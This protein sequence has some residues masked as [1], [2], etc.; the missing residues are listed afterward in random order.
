MD[1]LVQMEM[2]VRKVKLD[3]L[4]HRVV[5]VQQVILVQMEIKVLKV[6]KDQKAPPEKLAQQETKDHLVA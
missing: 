2:P 1:L 5:L 6:L 3:L 4:V